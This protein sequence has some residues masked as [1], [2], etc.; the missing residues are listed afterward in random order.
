MKIQPLDKIICRTPAFSLNDSLEDVLI[1]LKDK[2]KESSPAF[3]EFIESYQADDINQ[4][5]EKT[6]FTLWKYFN[7]AK[8]RSTPFGSFAA[9]AI[10][11]LT[12]G[13]ND[14][15]VVEK[16]MN[17][18]HYIDWSHKES[19]LKDTKHLFDSSTMFL[20]NSSFYFTGDE[21]RYIRVRENAHELAFVNAIPELNLIL[22]TCKRKTPCA[23]IYELMEVTF[24]MDIESTADLL[25]QLL[26]M[27]LLITDQFPNITGMDYFERLNINLPK[28][29]NDYII[30]KRNL[31]SGSFEGQLLKQIPALVN[32]MS[33][34]LPAYL[35]TDL[36]H[37]K[38]SFLKR[39][40]HQEV[41]L[42]KIM[43]PEIGIGYGNLAQQHGANPLVD[44]IKLAKHFQVQETIAY[45]E[46]NAFLLNKIVIGQPISL[47]EFKTNTIEQSIQLPNTFSFIFHLYRS[48]PVI[49]IAGGCTANALIGRF[50]M[51]NP[52]MESYGREIASLEQNANPDVIFF[53]IAYQAEKRVDNVNRR[54]LLYPY[55]LPILTWSDT[56]DPLDL[57]DIFVSIIGT[58]VILKSK[59][60][61]KRL[62]PRIPSAYNYTRSDLAVYRFLCDIQNQGICTQLGF[63]LQ[64]FFPKL[65][66]Y[67]RVNYK[68]I[69]VSPAMWLVP[70]SVYA[71]IK[72]DDLNR[73]VLLKTWLTEK[74]ITFNFKA[75]FADHTL[76]FNPNEVEDLKAFFSFCKQQQGDIYITEALISNEDCI[77]DEF[78]K[79][80]LPQYI[81]SYA[82]QKQ[83]YTPLSP[84]HKTQSKSDRFQL[85]GG[86]WL[87]FEL[88]SHTIKS[89]SLLLGK[90]NPLMKTYREQLKKWFFIRYTDPT[91]HLRLRLHLKNKVFGFKIIEALKQIMEPEM[92]EGRLIDLKIKTYFRETQ[93]YGA[94]RMDLVEQFFFTDSKAILFLL[95]KA[96]KENQLIA[97]SLDLILQ[98][99][100]ICMPNI[101]DQILFINQMANN[102]AS[103]MLIGP[104]HYKKINANF[105]EI[106]NEI[107]TL[108][109]KP[110]TSIT[111]RYHQLIKVILSTCTTNDEQHKLLADLIHMHVNRLFSVDQRMYE[112]IIYHYVLRMLQ[113]K[114]AMSKEQ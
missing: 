20:S 114:R 58:E 79:I 38:H 8:Y 59:K 103:E 92:Q 57:N 87:Y 55:E 84:A 15:M 94:K 30:A 46:F 26:N 81:A 98:W 85:P 49:A 70:S 25:L 73:L 71:A 18:N 96:K 112:T 2:I 42:A 51:G 86:D 45:G 93:R 67:P 88:Y 108:N 21:I 22:A 23:I 24:N 72:N 52:E 44:E 101:N 104:D 12:H 1:E 17:T 19:F 7:R 37:F 76:C 14:M 60:L 77:K 48:Q 10:V 36:D 95:G 50:T 56:A 31:L 90:I 6:W 35:N 105:N 4:L 33:Q 75:G 39:F 109:I 53:D 74:K 97:S 3:F 65:Q 13:Q 102:F 28:S 27:Q 99:C 68:E 9:I 54:Q 69:I 111:K 16:E 5:N 83:I 63:K 66:Y 34:H 107:G 89:N 61:G 40:E 100:E 110:P 82:H 91:P 64:D 78:G 80:Y 11:K 106:K 43:D 29:P 41:S 47:E 32:Y 62:M 113:I